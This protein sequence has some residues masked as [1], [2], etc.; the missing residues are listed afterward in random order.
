MI[1]SIYKVF[2]S[3]TCG[4]RT[5]VRPEMT[6]REYINAREELDELAKDDG[7]NGFI[8]T[9]SVPDEAAAA[10]GIFRSA[11]FDPGKNGVEHVEGM[12]QIWAPWSLMRGTPEWPALL[13]KTAGWLT[14][15]NNY[16]EL[17]AALH[18]WI[19][20]CELPPLTPWR[21]H[22]WAGKPRVSVIL[23]RSKTPKRLQLPLQNCNESPTAWGESASMPLPTLGR[24]AAESTPTAQTSVRQ[25]TSITLPISAA[26]NMPVV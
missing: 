26:S 21:R 22:G 3:G 9:R 19:E 1:W 5:F 20:Q 12:V 8:G 15:F 25:P 7:H 10:R 11:W 24:L 13:D 23:Q 6:V 18:R 2:G 16:S 4:V 17:K 14:Q